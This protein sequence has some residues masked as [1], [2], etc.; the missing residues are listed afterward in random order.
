MADGATACKASP[1]VR[2]AA[3]REL[4]WDGLRVGVLDLVVSDHPPATAAMKQTD[5]GDF[6]TA[7][8]GISSLQLGLPL[9]WISAR[10]KGFSLADVATW[11]SRRPAQLAGLPSKGRIAPGYD[12]DFCIFAPDDPF[13]VD[14]AMIRHKHPLTPYADRTLT[15]AVSAS[16]LRGELIDLARPRGELLRRDPK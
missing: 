2:E 6:G 15:G 11:M 4:L 5:T 10:R 7:W 3:N 12:A 1:P 16:I 14:P 13:L 8:G 9:I